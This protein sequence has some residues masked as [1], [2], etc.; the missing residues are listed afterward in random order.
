M[1][2]S[3]T[4]PLLGTNIKQRQ[5]NTHTH[6]TKKMSNMDSTKIQGVKLGARETKTVPVS[7]KSPA[8]LFIVK[9]SK[10]LVDDTGKTN[11]V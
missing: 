6:K 3:E 9:S 8:V 5:T 4:H 11:S 1:D 2:N 7:Y 10:S